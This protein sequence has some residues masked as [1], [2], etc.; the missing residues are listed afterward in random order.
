MRSQAARNAVIRLRANVLDTVLEVDP[1]PVAQGWRHRGG[2]QFN[3]YDLL[4]EP[5]CERDLL[6]YI[7]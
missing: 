5:K 7:S 3:R 2:A 6:I 4:L 1:L